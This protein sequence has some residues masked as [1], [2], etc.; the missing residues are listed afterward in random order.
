MHRCSVTFEF[1]EKFFFFLHSTVDWIGKWCRVMNNRITAKTRNASPLTSLFSS[2]HFSEFTLQNAWIIQWHASDRITLCSR[3]CLLAFPIEEK[4]SPLGLL[5]F[6]NQTS[7]FRCLT[8]VIFQE[9]LYT[10]AYKRVN[11]NEII[12]CQS[13]LF[14]ETLKVYYLWV[15]ITATNMTET[16]SKTPPKKSDHRVTEPSSRY[17]DVIRIST[18]TKGCFEK[19]FLHSVYQSMSYYSL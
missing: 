14:I 16:W 1:H 6:S 11:F 5:E 3:V 18:F 15:I 8:D 17:D 10:N 2:S 13:T 19:F 9:L 7:K 4:T 12:L